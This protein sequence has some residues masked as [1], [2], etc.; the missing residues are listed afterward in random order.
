[1]AF[2]S[3]GW[4]AHF[5][6]MDNG[7]NRTSK[8]YELTAADAATAAADVATILA[9]LTAV[10]DCEIV[11]YHFYESFEEDTVAYPAAG[12][13]K[14]NQALLIFDIV[15]NPLKKVTHAI[16]APKQ[17]IFIGATGPNANIVDTADADVVAYRQ[18]FQA[19]NECY[20]SD[21]EVAFTLVSGKRR[22]LRNSNG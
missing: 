4:R 7:G 20:I 18:M 22:H 6:L 13:Q 1:M 12:V 19:G 16:P 15:D 2:I 5:D 11:S 3:T 10:T 9:N 14:E 21:G 17:S 8:T